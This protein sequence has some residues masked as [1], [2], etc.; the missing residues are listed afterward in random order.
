MAVT[1]PTYTKL[2][3]STFVDNRGNLK[4][5]GKRANNFLDQFYDQKKFLTDVG[6]VDVF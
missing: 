3:L 6:L 1:K 2:A 4:E 5:G